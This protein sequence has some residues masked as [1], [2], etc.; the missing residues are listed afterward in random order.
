MIER[1]AAN[2]VP[3]VTGHIP[4]HL[5]QALLQNPDHNPVGRE[6]RFEAVALFADISGF[7]ALS[8]AL[9]DN[10]QNWY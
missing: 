3:G 2:F 5:A 1:L 6:Q 4:Y 9:A 10:G 7:T 8:E